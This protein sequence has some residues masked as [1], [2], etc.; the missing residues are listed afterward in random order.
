L[1]DE[2]AVPLRLPYFHIKILRMRIGLLGV[3]HLGRIHLK[4]LMELPQWEVVGFYDPD[5]VNA[6]KAIDEHGVHR[7]EKVE[8]LL[9]NVDAVDIVTPT[10]SHFQLAKKAITLGKHFFVEKPLVNTLDEAKKLVN[11]VSEAGIKA[12]VGHVERFNPAF[13]AIKDKKLNPMFIETHR[14]AQFNPRGTDVSVVLDLMIHDI[15]IILSIVKANVK[16]ISASGVPIIS[17]S[18]DIANAR[19]EFDNGCVANVTAS[20]ISMKNMRKSRIFQSD[21]YIS[22]DFLEKRTEV[23]SMRNEKP[24]E[25]LNFMEVDNAEGERKYIVFEMPPSPPVNSIKMELELFHEAIVQKKDPPV[26]VLEGYNAM[27]VA[28]QVLNKLAGDRSEK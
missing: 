10:V 22:V 7:F 19:I 20:R 26:T 16:R 2:H 24:D 21:A 23:I 8:D 9:E 14:L 13:L 11:L 25:S 15:D 28:Y 6:Q 18:P 3:G 17:R 4:C 1:K 27:K 12:Q 5:D